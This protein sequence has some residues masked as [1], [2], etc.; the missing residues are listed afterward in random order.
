MS[1]FSR[2]SIEQPKFVGDAQQ[3]S[4]QLKTQH[5]T[6]IKRVQFMFQSWRICS[7]NSFNSAAAVEATF[8]QATR[9]ICVPIAE[10]AFLVITGQK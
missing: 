9:L 5:K 8:Q 3:V 4:L 10:R 6:G 1:S 2:P 7:D